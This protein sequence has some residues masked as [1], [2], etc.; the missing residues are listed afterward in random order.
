MIVGGHYDSWDVGR[1]AMD[2]MGGVAISWQV[3]VVVY[4]KFAA[5]TDYVSVSLLNKTYYLLNLLYQEIH[6]KISLNVHT[7]SYAYIHNFVNIIIVHD[8]QE[9]TKTY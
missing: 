8:E 3:Y 4:Y 2:D 1:G 9:Y 5:V 6:H 7:N